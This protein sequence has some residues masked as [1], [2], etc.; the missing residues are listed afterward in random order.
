MIQHSTRCTGVLRGSTI[1]PT[2]ADCTR[3]VSYFTAEGK[4]QNC[5]CSY[6]CDVKATRTQQRR[7]VLGAVPWPWPITHRQRWAGCVRTAPE[8]VDERGWESGRGDPE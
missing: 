1:R 6:D 3:L 4:H 8:V 7:D 2:S 5:V